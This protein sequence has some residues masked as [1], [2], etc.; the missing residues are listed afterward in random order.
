MGLEGVG[1]W[2]EGEGREGELSVSIVVCCVW[3]F[4]EVGGRHPTQ[5]EPLR[6]VAARLCMLESHDSGGGERTCEYH[7][8]AR[9]RLVAG[10]AGKAGG[11]ANVMARAELELRRGIDRLW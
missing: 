1:R 9:L 8:V 7:E 6:P 11:R 5:R 10:K 3:V 4:L 2:G